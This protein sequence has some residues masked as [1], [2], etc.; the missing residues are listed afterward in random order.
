MSKVYT[1][2]SGVDVIEEERPTERDLRTPDVSGKSDGS[3]IE[4]NG[5][6]VTQQGVESVNTAHDTDGN[7][8]VTQ[9]IQTVGTGRPA[10]VQEAMA[11]PD[12]FTVAIKGQRCTL[13]AAINARLI[14]PG[15][16]GFAENK[17][18]TEPAAPDFIDGEP[19]PMLNDE[20]NAIIKQLNIEG[21]FDDAF[22]S[23]LAYAGDPRATDSQKRAA[24]VRVAEASHGTDAAMGEA[25]VN[26]I[27]TDLGHNI[28]TAV[29]SQLGKK[30]GTAAIDHLF[31]KATREARLRVI[32][33]AY[34]GDRNVVK[35]IAELW[36]L[37][38]RQ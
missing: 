25:M 32:R 3:M 35:H 23:A 15:R 7:R 29:K 2:R 28:T 12:K 38:N 27:I 26:R 4:V 10:S 37:N 22:Q 34:H 20:Q 9:T 24:F 36:R 5:N 6:G 19:V 17:L 16:D 33:M 13:E 1:N 14:N 18:E 8:D 31:D 21:G 11:A 30:D